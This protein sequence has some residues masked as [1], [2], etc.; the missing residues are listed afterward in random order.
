MRVLACIYDLRVGGAETS[1]LAEYRRL[2]KFGIDASVL[3]LGSDRTLE[4]DFA[5]AGVPVTFVP[6]GTRLARLRFIVEFLRHGNFDLVHTMLFWPDIVVRPVARACG[7][8]VVSSFTN[9]YYGKEHRHHSHHGA[10]GVIIAQLADAMT[11]KC[12]SGF[13]AI[14]SRSG[15]IMARRLGIKDSLITVIYRGRDIPQLGRRSPERRT[16]LREKFGLRSEFVFLCVGRQDY[17][18]AHEIAVRAFN[19][20]ANELPNTVLWLAGRDGGNT[21]IVNDA[22]AESPAR[23]RIVLLGERSDVSDLLVAADAFVM[24]SRFE[25]LAGA[26]IEAMALEVPLVLTDIPVF[27]E[28]S[29]GRALY[30]ARDDAT[31]LAVSMRS[32]ALD[33][34]PS[35]WTA[36]LQRRTDQLFN[37]DTVSSDLADFYRKNARNHPA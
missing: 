21:P 35:V 25:G 1:L 30:F 7:L 20:L 12:A 19:D 24:P 33:Q 34:Y 26:V 29:D 4:G 37:I 16:A 14:S 28:V 32:V 9:E 10:L 6:R 31:Q 22:I 17:Q 8:R 27:R 18:K 13:H 3:C 2:H 23:N 36:D 15:H 5:Q 11:A